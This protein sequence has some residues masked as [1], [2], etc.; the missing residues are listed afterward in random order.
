M[1]VCIP[2]E[3]KEGLR[4]RVY[5]H[6][7][8]APYFTIYDTEKETLKIVDNTNAHHSHGM[9]HP[10]GVLGASSI[11]AVVCR[12]MGAGAVQKLNEANVKAFR[13][14]GETASDVINQ[15]KA[16]ELEEITVQNACAQHGCN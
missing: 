16:N 9:C 13:A 14:A 10:L 12:G 11:D 3:N 2:T 5:G 7:G 15:Y 1:R 6:F 8:S 4:A